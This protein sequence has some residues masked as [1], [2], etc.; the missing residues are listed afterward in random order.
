[1]T[2]AA[3]PAS[4][5]ACERRNGPRPLSGCGASTR[6]TGDPSQ[7]ATAASEARWEPIAAR[8][9]Q[10]AAAMQAYLEQ[11]AL[12]LRPASIDAIELT[13]RGFASYLVEHDRKVRRLRHVRREHIEGYHRW[14]ADQPV[15]RTKTISRRTV[16]HR[17]GMLRVFFERV[18]EWGW[19]DAPTGCLIFDADLPKLDDPLPKFLDDASATA[20]MRAAATAAPVDRLVVEMLARTGL[21]AGELCALQADAVVRIGAT[22]WLRV[23]VGKLHNDRYL[24]L[25]PILVDLLDDWRA[26]ATADDDSGLLIT[27]RGRPL[28][29]HLVGRIVRRVARTAGIGHVH[30]HQLRHTLATQAINRGMSLEAIAAMLGHRS[31]RMTLVYA[32]IADRKVADEYFAV[33]EQVEALYTA[34]PIELPASAEGEQMRRL[35]IEMQRRLL[36]NG[37]C[38][39]PAELDC[40][41]E[42]VCE[43]CVHFATG[44]E[45]IPVLLRQRDH[46]TERGQNALV[47]IYDRLLNR[48]DTQQPTSPEYAGEHSHLTGSPA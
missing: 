44:P 48:I 32:R 36:G 47:T 31:L 18:A 34:E 29:R 2:V 19:A 22:H 12:S 43:T 1:V 26:N 42:T 35:R 37:Y 15:G 27:N 28:D 39:R 25:H 10:L 6:R 30:P 9:P 7:L 5:I 13:L 3:K 33:T 41:F 46:A 23:P 45:F 16:R 11:M 8:A 24:P 38:T 4:Q 21:R 14:L 40:A 17:L 20:L